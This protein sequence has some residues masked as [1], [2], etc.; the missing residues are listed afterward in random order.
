[1]ADK[2]ARDTATTSVDEIAAE[3]VALVTA[4]TKSAYDQS[5]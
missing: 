5:P 2:L 3:I 1:L 4:A